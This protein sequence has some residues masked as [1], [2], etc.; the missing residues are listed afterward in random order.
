MSD[1]SHD[2]SE[3][4]G[5]SCCP[6]NITRFMPSIPGYVYAVRGNTLFVNLYMG[7]EGQ[8]TLEG[9][10]VRIKQ[11]TR[12]P[13][14]GRIKLTL[15]HSPASSFTLALRI[16]GWVQQQPLPGTLYTYLDKDTPSYTISLNGK[17]VKPE[18]RNGYALLRGDWKGNDQIVLNL[19]MQVRKVIAD[20]QV[21]DDRNKYALMYGPIVYCIEANDHDGY[22]LDLFTEED[23][24]FSP[25]FKP[26]LLHGVMTLKGQGYHLL[27]DGHTTLPTSVTAIP[28][29]AWDNRGANEMNVWIPYTREASIPRRTETLASQ[30]QAS[31]SIP[32]GGY[33]LND[34]FE[35]RN[36]ADKSMQFHNW[37]QCFGTEEWAQYEWDQPMT[38]TEASVYWLELGHYDID[39]QLP[40]SWRLEYKAGEKWLPV[41]NTDPYE[42]AKDKYC[43]V[44]FQP[45]RTKALRLTAQLQEGKSAGILEWK[46]R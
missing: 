31:V 27:S 40:V 24:P 23:T 1:G 28:Y 43:T 2:R 15:D 42:I 30:A 45:V 33:G 18:V 29:Y 20:P 44:H 11:E 3:W 36:S 19:P 32:Y 10:P 26:D 14:E 37:W 5:C 39:F 41:K 16:P 21:I 46:V 34:R 13:W 25:E 6:S 17:T 4:F 8:I 9:Q 35:P 22:A 38:L 7:N 12:Y